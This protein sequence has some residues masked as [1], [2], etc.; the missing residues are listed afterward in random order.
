MEV[1]QEDAARAVAPVAAKVLPPFALEPLLLLSLLIH[2]QAHAARALRARFIFCFY[3]A[4][5]R[6]VG[7]QGVSAEVV[8][9]PL[10]YRVCVV[11]L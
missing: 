9:R 2:Q 3:T 8:E 6:I 5:R 10:F 1:G 11:F 7:A 4:A